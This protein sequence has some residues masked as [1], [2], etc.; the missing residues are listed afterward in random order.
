MSRGRIP[1]SS[2]R[3]NGATIQKKRPCGKVRTSS[4]LTIRILSYGMCDYSLFL[5]GPFS[6]VNHGSRSLSRGW[7]VLGMRKGG[8]KE[9][10]H[11]ALPCALDLHQYHDHQH[12][13][14]L[15]CRKGQPR[16]KVKLQ[17]GRR[18]DQRPPERRSM[19]DAKA[20]GDHK[21]LVDLQNEAALATGTC[22]LTVGRG[23]NCKYQKI[24]MP[25]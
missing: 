20:A 2:S 18:I 21:S 6:H 4:V 3:Y 8:R 23:N 1:S 17:L 22:Q 9:N 13:R 25:P 10:P 16:C 5:L 24:V 12:L 7:A 11:E 15:F 14:S 19:G